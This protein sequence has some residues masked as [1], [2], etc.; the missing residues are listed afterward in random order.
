MRRFSPRRTSGSRTPLFGSL[1][2]AAR[3]AQVANEPGAPPV[4][5]LV[6]IYNAGK[7]GADESRR[8]FIKTIGA[9]SLLLT[10]G[11]WLAACKKDENP[12]A[13]KS[14]PRIAIVGG[15]VAGLNC[16]YQL[17]KK[18][19]TASIYEANTRTGGRIFTASDILAP[20][21]TTELG[22][23]F[24]DTNHA[25]MLALAT[26]LGLPLYDTHAA[27]ESVL[28][29][30]AYF[31]DGHL[32]SEAEVI[33]EFQPL[34][35]RLTADAL[36]LEGDVAD[37][38]ALDNMS[39]QAYLTAIGASGWL[40][41]LLDIA[42]LTEFGLD[43]DV[44]SAC[45]L[46]DLITKDVSGGAFEIF[47][48]SDERYKIQGGNMRLVDALAA[49]VST[50]I[51]LGH[52]LLAVKPTG[53]AY[54]L[55]FQSPAGAVDVVADV[56][57]MCLPFS[58]LRNVDYS[59]LG[60]PQAKKDVIEQLGYGTNAKLL[61][62]FNSRV[63]RSQTPKGFSGYMFSNQAQ[64]NGWDNSQMQPGTSGGFTGFYGGAKGIAIGSGSAASGAG[65]L[66]AEMEALWPGATAA[67]NGNTAK[68]DWP[69]FP[70]TKG[71][72]ACYTTGQWS[73]ISGEEATTVDKIY[74][75]GEHC[76]VNFQGYMNGGAETGRVAAEAIMA[77][78]H[79]T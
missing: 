77:D 52:Q 45:N 64:V 2:R 31:I 56:I 20:G 30:D 73:T 72:Y 8:R 12:V 40:N 76:S 44:Q 63:W 68:M 37:Y 53:T 66:M 54:T 1:R 50:Q 24:I 27:S 3:L 43:T 5:E 41:K 36:L 47:G 38:Q 10:T 14:Q 46:I 22:G 48:E 58:T 32:Y 13:P 51:N 28:I 18:G 67:H 78:F 17:K 9:G 75:A 34:V 11:G 7:T 23:E 57:V 61:V 42:Y 74:F 26:E 69:A 21:L 70:W 62:G 35:A 55:T 33:T 65:F 29:K 19:Y 39:I 15:G 16:A 60:L 25:D 79:L 59:A 4:K 49:Q 71:S 6:D